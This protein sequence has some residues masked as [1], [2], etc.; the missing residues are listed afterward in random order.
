[1]HTCTKIFIQY[2]TLA[3]E[4]SLHKTAVL[5]SDV[6]T[7]NNMQQK[8]FLVRKNSQL[9]SW[10]FVHAITIVMIRHSCVRVWTESHQHNRE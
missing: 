7:D 6:Q 8:W 10:D 9:Y 4:V 1:M 5:T 2:N 3:L